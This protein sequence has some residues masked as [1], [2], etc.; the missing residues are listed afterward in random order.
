MSWI[1]KLDAKAARW[2]RLG[3][4]VYLGVKWFL[5]LM[6]GAS[7]AY[8]WA[9]RMGWQTAAWFLVV[10]FVAGIVQYLTGPPEPPA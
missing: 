10:P 2:P 4:A 6:G 8:S 1:A 3:R 5:V 9:E 7:L